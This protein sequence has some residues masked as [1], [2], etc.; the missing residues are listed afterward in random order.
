MFFF[1][2]TNDL[3]KVALIAKLVSKWNERVN[4]YPCRT[5]IQKL[6]YF[7]KS[8]GVPLGY[9]FSVYKYGPYSQDLFKQIDDM[10]I[11]GLLTDTCSSDNSKDKVSLYFTTELA[12]ELIASYNELLNVYDEKLGS[13][14]NCFKDISI[15]ELEL[16]S[17][18]HYY[19]IANNGFYRGADKEKLRKLTIEKVVSAK[20]DRF[21]EVEISDA[22]F[23]LEKTPLV[24]C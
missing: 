21:K 4:E 11:Y 6:C 15:R 18:I 14:V 16:I 8:I 5:T 10:V 20:K 7:A 13:L 19:Y 2:N 12:D 23:K 9:K 22:F 17:T 3:L 24:F 1:I